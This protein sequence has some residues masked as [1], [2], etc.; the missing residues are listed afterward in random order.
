MPTIHI[1]GHGDIQFIDDEVNKTKKTKDVDSS[2]LDSVVKDVLSHKPQDSNAGSEH[3][4]I[5]IFTD[6]FVD[7]QPKEGEGYRVE[8]DKLNK[9]SVEALIEEIKKED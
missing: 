4:A 8:Y 2:I 1:F 9:S 3:R 6:M 5:N 7:Y